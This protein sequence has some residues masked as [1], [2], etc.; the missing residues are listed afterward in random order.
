MSAGIFQRAFQW[1]ADGTEA[2][3]AQLASANVAPIVNPNSLV[4]LRLAIDVPGSSAS[5]VSPKIQVCDQLNG[6]YADLGN[7]GVTGYNGST[8]PGGLL[9]NIACTNRLTGNGTWQAGGNTTTLAS[10]AVNGMTINP[11]SFINFLFA[12]QIGSIAGATRYFRLYHSGTAIT[13]TYVGQ[14]AVG[15]APRKLSNTLLSGGLLSPL[16]NSLGGSL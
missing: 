16:V 8:T 15:S 6:T 7:Y 13:F 12:I 9:N 5:L 3:S 14:I 2:G 10:G 11:N 1:F 4:L